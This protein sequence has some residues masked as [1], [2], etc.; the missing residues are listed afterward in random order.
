[1]KNIQELIEQYPLSECIVGVIYLNEDD[2][3]G[4][5]ELK[6]KDLICDYFE[7]S[8]IIKQ[9]SSGKPWLEQSRSFTGEEWC[10]IHYSNKRGQINWSL[11][12]D[13]I[14]KDL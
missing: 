8:E 11:A 7:G 13:D 3:N 2:E 4:I 14:K 5:G 9:H 1:M 12:F 10:E 6:T